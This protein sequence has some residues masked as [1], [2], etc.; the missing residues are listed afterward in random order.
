MSVELQNNQFLSYVV[1][2]ISLFILVLF[3]KDQIMNAQSNIDQKEVLN[4][5]LQKVRVEQENLQKIAL[6]VGQ[7]DSV[8]KRFLTPFTEDEIIDY[9][10]SY[11]DQINT[12]SW[13][14]LINNIQITQAT[15]NQ[16]GFLEAKVN[17]NAQVSDEAV[18]KA[19]LDYLIAEDAEYRFFI[20]S[21]FHP[22]DG[23]EGNFNI[24]LP[25]KIFYR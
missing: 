19:F 8:T 15:E 22:L 7:E 17:V 9:F 18:M 24:Q 4:I 16:L 5:E 13:N 25:L 21:F 10:Y 12:G 14:L 6:E 1:V 23:R 2:L 3:T 20:D 11:A